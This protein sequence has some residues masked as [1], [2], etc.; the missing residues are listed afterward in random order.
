MVAPGNSCLA[1]FSLFGIVFM[2]ICS[3]GKLLSECDDG[4]CLFLEIYTKKQEMET[5]HGKKESMAGVN[6]DSRF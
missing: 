1:F 6:L 4:R 3:P 2:V 5:V